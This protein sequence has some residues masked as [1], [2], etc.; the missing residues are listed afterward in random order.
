MRRV[1][2]TSL[3]LLLLHSSS[4]SYTGDFPSRSPSLRFE[5]QADEEAGVANAKPQMHGRVEH[6]DYYKI[7]QGRKKALKVKAHDKM[8]DEVNLARLTS[9]W[10][11]LTKDG[12]DARRKRI[13]GLTRSGSMPRHLRNIPSKVLTAVEQRL[14]DDPDISREVAIAEACAAL[15]YTPK[16]PR[17]DE[18][19]SGSSKR[20]HKSIHKAGKRFNVIVK[21]EIARTNARLSRLLTPNPPWYSSA[22]EGYSAGAHSETAS[23]SSKDQKAGVIVKRPALDLNL[24]A[25]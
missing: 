6:R 19:S 23:A 20:R 24:P 25:S 16:T 2:L 10:K 1:R 13:L 5:K 8:P 4:L 17:S 11:K 15:H 12:R 21:E 7:H 9:D 18:D 14:F 22:S 3:L